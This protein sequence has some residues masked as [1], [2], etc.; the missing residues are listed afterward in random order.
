MP[1]G[2]KIFTSISVIFYFLKK[3]DARHGE[4]LYQSKMVARARGRIFFSL[5]TNFYDFGNSGVLQWEEVLMTMKEGS[6]SEG[7]MN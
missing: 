1:W 6:N 7:E 4:I 5:F 2:D 3:F